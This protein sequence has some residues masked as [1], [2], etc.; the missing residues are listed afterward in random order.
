MP[1]RRTGACRPSES[2]CTKSST[3]EHA[4]R[5]GWTTQPGATSGPA[6][7]RAATMPAMYLSQLPLNTFKDN[8]SD[9]EIVSHQ[10]MLRGG[11]IRRLA[12]GL[13]TW[14]PLGMRVL[15]KVQTIVR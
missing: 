6:E 10:L 4:A 14:M 7:Q 1:L 3:A 15:N 11:F 8:P 2:L 13:Y 5:I 12:A 9:A